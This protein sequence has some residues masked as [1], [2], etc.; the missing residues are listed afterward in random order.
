MGLL[1]INWWSANL[2]PPE[3]LLPIKILWK[4]SGFTSHSNSIW[5]GI[6]EKRSAD[7]NFLNTRAVNCSHKHF[8][9]LPVSDR[10]HLQSYD[11][12]HPSLIKIFLET[13]LLPVPMQRRRKNRKK[14]ESIFP[15]HF[16]VFVNKT[17]NERRK[18]Q[19][20][21]YNVQSAYA[22]QY[23][24]EYFLMWKPSWVSLKSFQLNGGFF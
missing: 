11:A 8:P 2:L 3:K 17:N 12:C 13:H 4:S 1:P 7:K 14:A 21:L 20:N 10:Q 5:S 18:I 22:K 16:Y 24:L 15:K 6:V 19:K 23:I 9:Y